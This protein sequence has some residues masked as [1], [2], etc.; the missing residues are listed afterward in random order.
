MP[1]VQT[2][3]FGEDP[4]LEATLSLVGN[5]VA[6]LWLSGETLWTCPQ[7]IQHRLAVEGEVQLDHQLCSHD[8]ELVEWAIRG[9]RAAAAELC[10]Q[11]LHTIFIRT[12]GD[13]CTKEVRA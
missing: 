10:E 7:G 1:V 13:P 5:G 12:G 11:L 6:E 9:R 2:Y 3:Q 4:V 8:L